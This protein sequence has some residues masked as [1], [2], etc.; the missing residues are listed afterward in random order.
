MDRQ[1]NQQKQ[2]ETALKKEQYARKKQAMLL[3]HEQEITDIQTRRALLK[4]DK[5]ISP[6]NFNQQIRNSNNQ[7]IN[8]E[9]RHFAEINELNKSVLNGGTSALAPGFS[10]K[11]VDSYTDDIMAMVRGRSLM[12]EG[13]NIYQ[14]QQ[15]YNKYSILNRR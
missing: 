11:P 3:R 13:G 7:Y 2:L 1:P 14:Y 10:L 4:N 9:R 8:M 5:K 15:K 12:S 6:I